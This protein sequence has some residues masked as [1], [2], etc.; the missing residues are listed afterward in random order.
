M[1]EGH[2]M[3]CAEGK[4]LSA[5]FLQATMASRDLES[6][7]GQSRTQEIENA[8]QYQEE[9]KRNVTEHARLCVECNPTSESPESS[10]GP[11]GRDPLPEP[12]AA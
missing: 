6:G 11:A 7:E 2:L 12:G 10:H 1:R 3:S 8:Q 5:L 9:C 4:R